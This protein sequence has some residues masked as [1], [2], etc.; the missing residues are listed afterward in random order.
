M[1][2]QLRLRDQVLSEVDLMELLNIEQSVL[3]NLRLERGFPYVR[4]NVKRRVYLTDE[5]LG[6]LKRNLKNA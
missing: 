2:E 1:P 4:L 5:V 3:D 6:W